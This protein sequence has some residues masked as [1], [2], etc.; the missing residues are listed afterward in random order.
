MHNKEPHNWMVD[1]IKIEY[2]CKECNIEFPTN[3]SVTNHVATV[4]KSNHYQVQKTQSETTLERRNQEETALVKI[5]PDQN[6]L[7]QNTA[8]LKAWLEAIPKE[9]FIY[10][11]DLF[12]K[13]FK[14]ILNSE[15]VELFPDNKNKYNCNQCN[16][17]ASSKR[18]LKAH[19][20]FVHE[21]K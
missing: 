18:C 6:F 16:I 7:T 12:E 17:R 19:K 3:S 2:K 1:E 20:T 5:V 21:K 13:D 15:K 9:A 4:H 10:E 8:D 14:E 11:E